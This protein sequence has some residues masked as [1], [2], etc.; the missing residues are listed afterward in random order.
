MAFVSEVKRLHSIAE[1][2]AASSVG[3]G[4]YDGESVAHKQLMASI[5]PKRRAPFD[6]SDKRSK[7]ASPEQLNTPGPGTYEINKSS[8][9][10][11]RM[12]ADSDSYVYEING[13]K[14]QRT[15]PMATSR[16]FLTTAFLK[17]QSPDDSPGPGQYEPSISPRG[18]NGKINPFTV[19]SPVS[20]GRAA[21][22][23]NNPSLNKM[24]VPSIPSRFLTPIIDS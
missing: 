4:Q 18:R 3:P 17:K 5:F 22:A 1:T 19:V 12:L 8:R 14:R 6:S 11:L 10:A 23:V 16:K 9:S 21:A 13:E 15:Q 2:T 24:S 20:P 7:I